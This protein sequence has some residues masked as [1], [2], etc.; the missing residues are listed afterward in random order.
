[1]I[2]IGLLPRPQGVHHL[3]FTHQCLRDPGDK[4]AR[5]VLHVPQGIA[6]LNKDLPIR[7]LFESVK[8]QSQNIKILNG[9]LN[10]V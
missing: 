2:I 3:G 7:V 10:Q 8:E 6:V 4:V 5:S 9:P 1:M